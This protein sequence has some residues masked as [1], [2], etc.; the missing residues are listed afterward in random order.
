MKYLISL[1]AFVSILFFSNC[2]NTNTPNASTLKNVNQIYL[3]KGKEIAASTFATLSSNLQKTMK[4]EGVSN[5]VK[6]CNLAAMPLVDSLSQI[7]N[8]EIRRTS[9]KIRNPKNNPTPLELEQLQVYQKQMNAGEKLQPLV[10]EIAA[11]TIAFYAP[12]H[13]M[14]LCQK[15]HGKIDE[16]LFI[17]DY[18]TIVQYYPNDKAIGYE[19]G[20]WRGM[21]SISFEK[22]KAF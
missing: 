17:K 19:T 6:Y 11:S 4:N 7:Y 5:A 20:D 16:T 1:I 13:I 18:K 21:W 12:I 14:P 9:F 10:K 15:C 3:E 2:E 8:A 22:E